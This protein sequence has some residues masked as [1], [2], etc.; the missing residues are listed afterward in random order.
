MLVLSPLA[1]NYILGPGNAPRL[2]ALCSCLRHCS[3]TQASRQD[4]QRKRGRTVLSPV[5]T[6]VQM[7]HRSSESNTSAR[8]ALTQ[9]VCRPLQVHNS[10]AGRA[11]A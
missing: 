5:K 6:T 7:V 2:L 9:E 11:S 1:T 3:S 10:A 4:G 8:D